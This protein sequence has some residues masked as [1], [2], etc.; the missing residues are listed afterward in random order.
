MLHAHA[1][2]GH[3]AR[4][5]KAFVVAKQHHLLYNTCDNSLSNADNKLACVRAY[6]RANLHTLK[7]DVGVARDESRKLQE[8]LRLMGDEVI[9]A[10]RAQSKAKADYASAQRL[11][12][13][14]FHLKTRSTK[15]KTL[16]Y[17]TWNRGS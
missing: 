8:S 7:Q 11:L 9:T 6:V 12:R 16:C 4:N 15:K 17:S 14:V 1:R 10:E 2:R 13:F 3:F 5:A